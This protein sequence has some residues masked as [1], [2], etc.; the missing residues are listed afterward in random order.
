MIE[1]DGQ[2]SKVMADQ[3]MTVSKRRLSKKIGKA[4][5]E[6]MEDIERVMALQLGISKYN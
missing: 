6:E 1:I 4:S 5:S 3:L 2:A